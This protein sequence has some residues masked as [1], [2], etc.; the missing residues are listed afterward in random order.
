ME[1]RFA[2]QDIEQRCD[3]SLNDKEEQLF[4]RN[5]PEPRTYDGVA[6]VCPDF[7]FDEVGIP[8]ESGREG[9]NY[10]TADLKEVYPVKDWIC[11][12]SKQKRKGYREFQVT[13]GVELVSRRRHGVRVTDTKT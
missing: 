2:E 11:N 3:V 12:P 13:G 6:W 10:E 1:K 8:W 5:S 7:L 9:Q 4:D